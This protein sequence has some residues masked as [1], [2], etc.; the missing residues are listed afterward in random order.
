MKDDET[1]YVTKKEF[2]KVMMTV[3]VFL[4]SSLLMAGFLDKGVLHCVFIFMV[5]GLQMYYLFKF[6]NIK[7][8]ED[9]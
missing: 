7:R 3:F 9:K 1:L 6:N 8:A 2:Y 4:W 5:M